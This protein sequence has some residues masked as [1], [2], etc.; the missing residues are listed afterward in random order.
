MELLAHPLRRAALPFVFAGALGLGIWL[1]LQLGD[2]SLAHCPPELVWYGGASGDMK[3]RWPLAVYL[4]KDMV[5]AAITSALPVLLCAAMAPARKATTARIAAIGI[6]AL[7]LLYLLG[8]SHDLRPA[9]LL[10]GVG[11]AF[12]LSPWLAALLVARAARP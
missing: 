5:G 10:T 3:C 2:F 8:G 4:A 1:W 12:A 6:C 7:A 9:S 11:L